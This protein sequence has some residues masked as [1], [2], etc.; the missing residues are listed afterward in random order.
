MVST[1]TDHETLVPDLTRLILIASGRVYKGFNGKEL[2]E[3][4]Q[5]VATLKRCKRGK[6]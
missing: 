6:C 3:D 1:P 5:T 2:Y 4:D